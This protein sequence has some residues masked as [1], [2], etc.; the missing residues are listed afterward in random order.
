MYKKPAQK[1]RLL[2]AIKKC[3]RSRW[4]KTQKMSDEVNDKTNK[5]SLDEVMP[6]LMKTRS[7]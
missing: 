1:L 5:A 3:R 6:E 4:S 2:N 7:N